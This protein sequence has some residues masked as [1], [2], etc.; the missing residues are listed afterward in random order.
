MKEIISTVSSK[1]QI[2]VPAV[3]RRHLGIGVNEKVAFV[4][5]DDGS[6][7]L[8]AP[9][10]PTIA[11]LVG[12]AGKLSKPMAWEEMRDIAHADRKKG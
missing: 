8:M 1:G 3:V 6:V 12:A 2:T 5:D 4:I 11:S 7:K 9:R 10:F